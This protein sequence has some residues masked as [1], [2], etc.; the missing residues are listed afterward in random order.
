MMLCVNQFEAKYIMICL[1]WAHKYTMIQVY[2]QY[3]FW[4]SFDFHA[5]LQKLFTYRKFNKYAPFISDCNVVIENDMIRRGL[6]EG[7]PG[8]PLIGLINYTKKNWYPPV[9]SDIFILLLAPPGP[10]SNIF[11]IRAWWYKYWVTVSD[12]MQL[13]QVR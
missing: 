5:P 10:R 7:A 4:N 9:R 2:E 3:K 11:W 6:S 8:A 13:S 1:L 12:P